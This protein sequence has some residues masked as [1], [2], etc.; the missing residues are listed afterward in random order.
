MACLPRVDHGVGDA[1]EECDSLLG[2]YRQA[3]DLGFLRGGAVDFGFSENARPVISFGQLEGLPLVDHGVSGAITKIATPRGAGGG[4]NRGGAIAGDLGNGNSGLV[5]LH[6]G[7]GHHVGE[8]IGIFLGS[9]RFH[10]GSFGLRIGGN[11]AL[12]ETRHHLG[13]NSRGGA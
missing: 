2:E 12:R 4:G 13:L 9:D 6:V 11:G 1:R 5:G 7:A 3:V 8:P 10:H